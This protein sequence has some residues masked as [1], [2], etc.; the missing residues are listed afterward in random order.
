M[1]QSFKFSVV[2]ILLLVIATK[3]SAQIRQPTALSANSG[4][5]TGLPDQW[6]RPAP[7]S[8]GWTDPALNYNKLLQQQV[9]D[10][11][12][13]LIGPYKVVG[14]SF[15]FG[16]HHK[17]DMFT[18]EAK[19]YNIFVSYNTYNQEVEFYSTS[20]PNTPLVREPGSVDSF[21]IHKND[22]IGISKQLKF[23]YGSLLGSKEKYYYQEIFNGKNYSVFKRY[24]SD[25]GYVGSNLA[26]EELRQFDL[27]TEYY[28]SSPDNK[29]LKK[30]KANASSV[31]K[32]FKD[33]KDLT[34]VITADMFTANPEE[35][36]SKAF[37][38]LNEQ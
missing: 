19:A 28:Y 15:L 17:A 31:I 37:I 29:G 16:H 7:N 36:L 9:N 2:A 13:K 14:S 10:G 27:Q 3:L 34:S 25:L 6:G 32:E 38:S 20:N 5:L 23:I 35:A 30:L 11:N 33:V 22:E 18:P 26:Q 12:Y 21:I 8:R 4:S 1:K 24:K